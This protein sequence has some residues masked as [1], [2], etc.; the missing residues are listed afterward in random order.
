MKLRVLHHN[1]CFDG[2]CSAAVFTRLHRECVGGIADYE[3]RGLAHQAGGGEIAE[4]VFAAGQNAVVDFKY[5]RSA[6]L[7]WW[8]DHHQSAFLTAEDRE[9][10]D[11]RAAGGTMFFNPESVSCTGWIAAVG[12]ANFGFDPQGLAELLHWADIVDGARFES[13]RQAVEMKEPALQLA[14][15]IEHAEGDFIPRVIPLLT[16]RSLEQI[17]REPFVAERVQPILA[18]QVAA[19]ELVQRCAQL[20]DG[21]IW[22]DLLQQETEALSKFIPY[23]Y[24][25]EATYAVVATQ[26]KARTKLSVGTNPWTTRPADELVNLAAICERFGGG[27][28][29][30]VG[31]ISFAADELARTRQVGE[32]IVHELRGG[33]RCQ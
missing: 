29:A 5:S 18:R 19:M 24:F 9:D 30:R 33:A 32:G 3:Y 23:F 11:R 28:H 22:L 4:D 12:K 2:A 31:A 27:G 16:S 14:A 20:A 8:F 17:V 1:Q 21:V 7:T 10:F 26:S 15:A 25:P 13:A 6:R